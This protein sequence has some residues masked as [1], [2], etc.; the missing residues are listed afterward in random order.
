MKGGS[1]SIVAFDAFLQTDGSPIRLE[2]GFQLT[3][4][5]GS[6][7]GHGTIAQDYADFG[8]EVVVDPPVS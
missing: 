3:G 5:D 1:A 6:A 7:A 8:G 4:A 2:V